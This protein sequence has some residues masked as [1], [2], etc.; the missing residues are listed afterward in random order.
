[1][2][3]STDLTDIQW[4]AV[5]PIFKEEVGNHGNRTKWSKRIL[6]NAVLYLTKNRLP[7]ENDSAGFSSSSNGLVIL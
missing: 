4:Q 5:E 2:S 1:L 7:M 6:M 3:H